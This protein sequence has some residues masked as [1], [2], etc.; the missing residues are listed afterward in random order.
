ML[1]IVAGYSIIIDADALTV[2]CQL[3]SIVV[4]PDV[5]QTKRLCQ[6]DNMFSYSNSSSCEC[7]GSGQRCIY[8][9]HL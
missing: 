6:V 2:E 3:L 9:E 4:D 5:T 8:M 1:P 7:V